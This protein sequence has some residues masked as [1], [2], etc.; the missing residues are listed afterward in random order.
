MPLVIEPIVVVL[1]LKENA[2][3]LDKLRISMDTFFPLLIDTGAGAVFSSSSK[4][5]T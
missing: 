1:D 3:E 5:K 4:G 2:D